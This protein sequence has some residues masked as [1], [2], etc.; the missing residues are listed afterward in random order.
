[1]TFYL[2]KSGLCLAF[3]LAFY[4]LVLEREKMHRFNRFYLLGSVLFSFVAPSVIIYVEALEA[5]SSSKEYIGSITIENL[6]L[7]ERYFTIQNG[8][9]AIYML[10]SL[11]FLIRFIKNLYSIIHKIKVNEVIKSEHANFIPV[12]DAILPHT[13]WNYIFINKDEYQSQEIEE[14]LFTH[15]L[16]H[17]TQKHTID[18]LIIELLQIIFWFNPL[19]FM[20]KKAI[21]LNHEFLADDKVIASHNNISKY[22]S[23]LLNK[24]AWKNEYY[25]AS[26]LN[27]SLTKKRLLMMKTPNS[28][29]NILIKKLAIIPFIAG[30]VFLFATRV[31]AQTKEKKTK[32]IEVVELKKATD[33]QM[34]EYK[35]LL[36]IAE[37]KQSFKFKDL[38]RLRHLHSLMSA[39]QKKAVKNINDVL[40]PPVV[41]GKKSP[42][43]K[44]V[45]EKKVPPKP[46]KIE[47]IRRKNSNAK[48]KL[49]KSSPRPP[50]KKEVIEIIEVPQV[51]E[52][53]EVEELEEVEEVIES[54]VVIDRIQ[55]IQEK[56]D[57][58]KV[59]LKLDYEQLKKDKAAF[60][61][62]GK[63]ISAKKAKKYFYKK[64]STVK[65]IEVQ[66]DKN[67]FIK[68]DIST[69]NRKYGNAATK[70][71]LLK[72]NAYANNNTIEK[73]NSSKNY[74][75]KREIKKNLE[76][77]NT[78][79]NS[80]AL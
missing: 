35:A 32:L 53:E 10:V 74:K 57:R 63:K 20:I 17:V 52:V 45:R 9:I 31:E 41:I 43:A 65:D 33:A 61:L 13:F 64:S 69:K 22:Q 50:L 24:A 55:V 51:E 59:F 7:F 58:S 60:Y 8:L 30:L 80:N 36:K 37:K 56:E 49:V 29:T 77:L 66:K 48:V 68:V 4:H 75:K 67:K 34:K 42:K 26:N 79:S 38:K 3:L 18:V 2:L 21:Q 71:A 6:S 40:P 54:P 46:T 16:A 12:E 76:V 1:M 44:V 72:I 78:F 14:E 70:K 47:V 15:E 28:K 11:T 23:L 5:V 25:L 73:L 19:F 39:K 62:N 27:Y